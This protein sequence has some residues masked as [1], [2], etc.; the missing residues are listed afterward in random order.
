M[1]APGGQTTN[2]ITVSPGSTTT[3]TVTYSLA[4]QSST[5]GTG[6]LTIGSSTILTLTPNGTFCGLS[7]GSIVCTSTSGLS[8]YQYSL[9]GG[10]FQ[11]LNSFSNLASGNDTV[12]VLDASGCT[13]TTTTTIAQSTPLT[14]TLQTDS[15]LC[16]LGTDGQVIATVTNGTPNY[17]YSLN[18]GP[19][20]GANTFANLTAGN[21]TVLVTDA[22]GCTATS[23]AVVSQPAALAP[24]L[25]ADSALCFGDATGSITATC[26]GGHAPYQYSLNGGALQ[27]NGTFSNI[28]A[29][30]YTVQVTDANSCTAIATI[31]IGQPLPVAAV[32]V[33]VN[34]SC[35]G[36]SDGII[37]VNVSGGTSPYTYNWNDNVITQNRSG[38]P[39]GNYVVTITDSRGITTTTSAVISVNGNHHG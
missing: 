11:A 39:P 26:T 15:A 30:N 29:G 7:N 18:N 14:F 36:F 24:V 1:W 27:A 3:Y 25:I 23:S 16:N 21:Y 33:A 19:A 32:N 9:N 31:S 17:T 13:T 34:D 10:A 5:T 2:S 6:H 35:F 28:A 20:Q 8:P 22:N 4:G 37:N 38:L 12:V